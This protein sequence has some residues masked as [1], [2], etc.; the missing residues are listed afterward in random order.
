MAASLSNIALTILI[1]RTMMIVKG[2][3]YLKMIKII[4]NLIQKLM[5]IAYEI[6]KVNIRNDKGFQLSVTYS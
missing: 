6:R 5:C 3:T 2:V 4:E 1:Y